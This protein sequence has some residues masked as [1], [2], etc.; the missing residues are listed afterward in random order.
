MLLAAA[1][2]AGKLPPALGKPRKQLHDLVDAAAPF[3]AGNQEAAKLDIFLD[4][5]VRE[6]MPAFRHQRETLS[7]ASRHRGAG[8]VFAIEFDGAAVG[9]N[10]GDCL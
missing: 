3:A 4:R 8:D 5:H 1:H 10:A 7:H 6:Q 2:G 9:D